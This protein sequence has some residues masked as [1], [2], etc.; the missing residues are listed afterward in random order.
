MNKLMAMLRL[1]AVML[2]LASAAKAA[3]VKYDFVKTVDMSQWKSVAWTSE[4]RDLSMKEQ[5]IDDAVAN[6]FTAKGYVFV[7]DP[8]KADFL[9]T[10]R[11]AA[12]Q[13][14]SLQGSAWT[15]AFGRDF[16][17]ARQAMG[18][19]VVTV[20]DRATG[21]VAWKGMVSDAPADDPVQADKRVAKAV[22]KL[23]RKFPSRAGAP[24]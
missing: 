22:E 5:R 11:A 24:R 4:A 15:P 18:S 3:T 17:V 20:Y 6:G 8:A 13:D 1:L 14:V 19:L 7:D 21:K 12:W 2:S 16:R 9:I 10:W 23:L